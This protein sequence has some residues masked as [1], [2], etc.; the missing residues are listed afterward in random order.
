MNVSLFPFS[1]YW[2]FYLL[3]AVFVV[4]LL[5][6]DL[7][8]FH[9]KA[10]KVSLKEAGIWSV[11]WISLALA[12]NYLLYQYSLWKFPLDARLN[13]IPGFD[14][15]GSA[16]QVALEFLTGFVI[17]KSLA[18][19]NLFIFVV[20]F[21]YFAIPALYQH[22]ILFYGILGALF[23]RAIFIALGA[24]LM[25]YH[26][27]IIVF[28]IFLVLT[29]I[30]LLFSPEKAPDIERNPLI[31]FTKHFLPITTKLEGQKFFTRQNGTLYGTP[32]LLAL[33]FIE[34]TD[35]IFAIDSIPAIYAITGEPF[36]VFTSNIF[37]ILGMR[38]LYFLLAGIMHL[39]RFLKHGLGL[40]LIFVGLKMA[41]LNELFNGKFPIGWS[42]GIIFGIILG[43]IL[44][45]LV[46]KKKTTP[47]DINKH[48][49][50]R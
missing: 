45:S 3:F 29:G 41:W 11:I 19:D 14:P 5:V 8:V 42:L 38:S 35:I 2:S 16:K 6:L 43:A 48:A 12:F 49:P 39:F 33:V 30:K 23:F 28:G 7:G 47:A 40:V 1:E 22:R 4:A 25:Q 18:I 32:L 50:I 34:F 15:D 31:R 20:V 21:S 27:L 17:E 10:H 44:I 9:R 46:W 13:A 37:A 36:I 26:W 24:V